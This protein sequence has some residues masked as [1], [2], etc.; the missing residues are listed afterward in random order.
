MN[1]NYR[2]DD[3]NLGLLK[4]WNVI[5]YFN[6][7]ILKK[8]PSV[9]L[10]CPKSFSSL[11]ICLCSEPNGIVGTVVV[12]VC[13]IFGGT[14]GNIGLHGECEPPEALDEVKGTPDDEYKS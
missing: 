13:D 12:A 1:K 14:D 4:N 8:L 6:P 3:Q 2:Y 9:S 5:F 10:L 7:R 11:V